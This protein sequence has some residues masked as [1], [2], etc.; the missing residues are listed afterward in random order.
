MTH[1]DHAN[2]WLTRHCSAIA[3]VVLLILGAFPAVG[4][5]AIDPRTTGAINPAPAL[6]RQTVPGSEQFRSAL[7]LLDEDK[8]AAYAMARGLENDIER[9]VIQWA[10]IYY[11]K[12]EIDHHA[13]L[14]FQADAPGYAASSIYKTRMEQALT[15]ASPETTEALKLLGGE[16]PNTLDAQIMLASAYVADGQS[17]RARAIIRTIW[18]KN[19]L[20][21]EYE[22]KILDEFNA[23]LTREDHWDRA[24]HLLMHDRAR[25]AERIMG[26]LSPA[27]KSLAVARIA[28][29]RKKSAAALFDKVDPAYRKH[30]L[31]HFARGQDARR[32]GQLTAAVQFLDQATGADVPD[33]AEFWYERRL[34]TRR[35]LAKGASKTA[36]AAAAGYT[37]GPEGRVVDA[38]FHAGWIALK[39]LNK[40]AI[41]RDHFERMRA[42]S[43]LPG[44][45]TQSHYWLGKALQALDENEKARGVFKTAAAFHTLYYGQLA[46]LELGIKNV[47]IRKLPAWRASE[48]I[49]EQRELVKAVRLLAAND[50]NAMAER[51]VRRLVQPL[52]DPGEFLLA[53]RLA[54]SIGAHNVAILIADIADRRGV[55]LDLFSFPKDGLP[56][57]ARLAQIDKAAIY[58]IARQESKFDVDA[59]SRSGARG[60]MQLMPAT[61]KETARRVGV[62][63]S[64]SKLT[65]DAAY[66]V[67]LGSTYLAAQLKRFDGSLVLAA[68]AYNAG[69]GNVNKWIK[70]FGDPRSS[71]I[72]PVS[73]IEAIPFVETR[74]YT[75]RVLGNY[76]VYRARLGDENLTITQALR[77]IPH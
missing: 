46:G 73:W 41:A 52:K 54:Q 4:N 34:I 43:T 11:G 71:K 51:L 14:R 19:F 18:V 20:D 24:V 49:F 50:Q 68:A 5:D 2:R 58:A 45:I 65:R 35:A 28:V 72:D 48:A 21:A 37:Q 7:V 30:S 31:F 23:L 62:S 57:N 6:I 70:S 38:N 63:Y 25:G 40:P 32:K 9:R 47:R 76:M 59:V 61:A 53:A 22:G 75:Q 10:A 36:Y 16:M 1:I 69:G 66:N 67:L 55:A 42:L 29:S 39:F 13:V 77:R 17:A 74:K 44:S 64:T 60:L 12:G 33:S 3:F 8:A 27:Q 15:E 26:K 56:A